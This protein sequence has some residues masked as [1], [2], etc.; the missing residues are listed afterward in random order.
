LTEKFTKPNGKEVPPVPVEPAKKESRLKH[1]FS[2]IRRKNSTQLPP[3]PP[4][5]P[6]TVPSHPDVFI[7]NILPANM[8]VNP[9]HLQ[10]S[11]LPESSRTK[12]EAAPM[13]T[14]SPTSSFQ[15]FS[16]KSSRDSRLKCESLF[17]F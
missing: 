17:P 5:L 9:M 2:P 16:G 13:G 14:A 4:P 12:A 3:P 8:Y 15:V 10:A 7:N 6:P 1:F 11:S